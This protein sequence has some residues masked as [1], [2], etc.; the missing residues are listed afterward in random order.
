MPAKEYIV[1]YSK[2]GRGCLGTE[3]T[4]SREQGRKEEF[5]KYRKLGTD[6]RTEQGLRRDFWITGNQVR[7]PLRYAFANRTKLGFCEQR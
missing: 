7:R 6:P 2:G 3:F 5:G 4:M 1:F